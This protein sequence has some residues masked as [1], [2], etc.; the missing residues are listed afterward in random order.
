MLD[1]AL[2]E[3]VTVSGLAY[4]SAEELKVKNTASGAVYGCGNTNDLSQCSISI[5]ATSDAP[6]YSTVVAESDGT[7]LTFTGTNLNTLGAT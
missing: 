7:T 6:T 1:Y 4:A 5:L 3:C 2:L